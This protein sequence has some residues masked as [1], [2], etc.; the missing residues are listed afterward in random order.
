MHIQLEPAANSGLD[1]IAEHRP[2]QLKRMIADIPPDWWELAITRGKEFDALTAKAEPFM[3]IYRDVCGGKMISHDWFSDKA[4]IWYELLSPYKHQ[5]IKIMELGVFEGRS[6]IF[7]LELLRNSTI[8]ALDHF[9][10]TRGWTS[11]QGI[12]LPWDTEE[13]FRANVAPYGDRVET[14]VAPS[15]IGLTELIREARKYD[16][17]YV[18]ASHTAPDVL[19]D[20]I[21][22]W[23]LL[24]VGGLFIWDDFLLDIWDWDKGPVGPGVVAFL[25]SFPKSYELVHAGWQ[26]AVRKIAEMS[27]MP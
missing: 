27:E 4:W 14:R 25:K 15:W 13:A 6:I 7:A 16:I 23:K 5:N 26:V 11:S 10:L 22:A 3:Q 17:C 8:T 9:V 20:S 1:L 12:T 2:Y 19:A 21:L 24:K 18:D